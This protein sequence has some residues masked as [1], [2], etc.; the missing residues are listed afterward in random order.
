MN[1]TIASELKNALEGFSGA[2]I[3]LTKYFQESFGNETRIDYGTGHE[4]N[5]IAFCCCLD[6]IGFF[7]KADDR[8]VILGIFHR[9]LLLCRRLQVRTSIVTF[10]KEC[11]EFHYVTLCRLDRLSYGA[12]WKPW[13]PL[14]GRF[15]VFVF[16]LWLSSTG[17]TGRPRSRRFCETR[18][19][20]QRRRQIYVFAS[21]QAHLSCKNWTL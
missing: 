11:H 17:F 9:Y 7:T 14:I 13:S 10:L 6:K 20:R 19:N 4:T 16:S 5:F 18:S 2:E 1:E 8:A 12:C 3:E 21:D 15:P